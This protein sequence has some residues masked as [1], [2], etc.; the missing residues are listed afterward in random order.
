MQQL[1][2]QEKEEKIDLRKTIS[3][4]LHK[5]P[6]F[7]ASVLVCVISAY[8]YLRYSVPKYQTKTTLKFDKKQNDLT[9]ALSDL[10]NLGIGLG[11]SDELKSEAAVVT[12]RP[13]LM[14]VVK[15][16][17]LN[18][19]YFNTGEIKDSQLFTKV[20]VS[21]EI[22]RFKEGFVSSEYLIKRLKGDEFT[23][24]SE[25]HGNFTGRFEVPVNLDFGTVVLHRNRQFD[26]K[27]E[28]KIIF[29]NPIEKVKK[30]EK[31]DF[32][33]TGFVVK[34]FSA[35]GKKFY[36]VNWK[37]EIKIDTK[38]KKENGVVTEDQLWDTETKT[39]LLGNTQKSSHIKET[40]FLD[41]NKT[42]SHDVEKNRNEGFEFMLNADGSFNLKTKTQNS[43]YVYN[44]ATSKYEMKGAPKTSGTKK[45]K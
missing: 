45:K 17:N 4:Y 37:E 29:S 26:V 42:A 35:Q 30:L 2:F 18:V 20:P 1:E 5:W 19:E 27:P 40:I 14:Q 24:S 11:N 22:I 13:I 10:D 6:W 39:L 38:L 16:L 23:L 3:K 31:T 15:N 21:G 44:V 34:S 33:P 43:T 36:H 25:K 12:S 28:Y 9:S 32:K 8:I 7:L 41:A